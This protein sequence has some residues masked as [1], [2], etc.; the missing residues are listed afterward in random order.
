MSRY[1][2]CTEFDIGR[3]Q[4]AAREGRRVRGSKAGASSQGGPGTHIYMHTCA[5]C[6]R[7]CSRKPA[8]RF[9]LTFVV[10][11]SFHKTLSPKVFR[12]CQ[13]ARQGRVAREGRVRRE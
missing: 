4:Q 10:V 1:V 13:V 6:L 7:A 3:R 11:L 12:E 9:D 8:P 5:S 2:A